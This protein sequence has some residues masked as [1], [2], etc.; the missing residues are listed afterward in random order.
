MTDVMLEKTGIGKKAFPVETDKAEALVK[1][2]KAIKLR[3]RLYELLDVDEEPKAAA[4][5]EKAPG[6][7]A[8]KKKPTKR[9]TK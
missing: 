7:G 3:S 5:K 9:V 8:K 2:G 4:T 1:A 6:T